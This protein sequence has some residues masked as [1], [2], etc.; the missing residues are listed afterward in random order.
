MFETVSE[1]LS[2]IQLRKP[3]IC[4]A[5]RAIEIKLYVGSEKLVLL[6]YEWEMKQAIYPL[7]MT[8]YAS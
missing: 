7:G 3:M 1:V 2:Y 4:S 8:Q 5:K 6:V